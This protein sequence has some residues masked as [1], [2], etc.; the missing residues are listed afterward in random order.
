MENKIISIL[1]KIGKFF[2]EVKIELKKV[3]W[4]TKEEL[5]DSTII[6]LISVAILALIIGT[7]DGIMSKFIGIIIN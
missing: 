1:G 3:S 2:K 6:V 4:S 7:F 5:K